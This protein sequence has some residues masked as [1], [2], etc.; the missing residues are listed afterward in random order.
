MNKQLFNDLYFGDYKPNIYFDNSKEYN[1]IFKKILKV[2]RQLRSKISES[3]YELV[4]ELCGLYSESS[5][6][7]GKQSYSDGIKFATNFLFN[8]LCNNDSEKK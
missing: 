1:V 3:D 7:Y 8:A 2:Q 5:D 4:K 6:F